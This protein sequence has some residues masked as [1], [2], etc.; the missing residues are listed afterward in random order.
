MKRRAFFG[1]LL[2]AH[3]SSGPGTEVGAPDDKRDPL[4]VSIDL[5]TKEQVALFIEGKGFFDVPFGEPD[6]LGPLFIG[7]SC[8]SC[9]TE[10]GTGPGLV[11]KMAVVD[12]DG[13]P[14]RDQSRLPFGHTVR[15]QIAAGAT[16][17]VL[18]PD[19]PAVKTTI[20]MGPSVLGRGYLEAI[21]DSEIERV[22]AEQANRTDAIAGHIN[23]VVYDSEPNP[24]T[25]FGAHAKGDLL[26]GRFGVKARIATLDDFTADALQGDMGVTNPLRPNELP[27]PDRLL[28][29]AKPGLDVDAE[30]LND[31]ANYIR[32][33]AIPARRG[34]TEQG[35][36]L[37]ERAQCSACH[38]PS[39]RTRADY[40]IEQLRSI[41]AP[42]YSDLLVH[43]MGRDLADGVTDGD[44]NWREWRTT[45]LIGLRFAKAYLHD[46][47]ATSIED[48]IRKHAS[49]G[50]EASGSVRL[51]EA[52]TDDERRA[53]IAFVSA[54]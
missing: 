41:D 42:V 30:F 49:S 38:V 14:A 8:G 45:P 36:Q 5:A 11:Q 34:L 18:P 51:F 28:D 21:D 12:S 46:G 31:V 53:L 32:L 1:L 44:A 39:L 16:M 35:R 26:I 27:N 24:D 4:A 6:G 2:L 25:T 48:A 9:H 19:D 3:C 52:F 10:V 54:L 37:F 40:P 33:I 13:F 29:D 43:D 22:A 7:V 15:P 20:R 23:R 17:P 47:R 50:S